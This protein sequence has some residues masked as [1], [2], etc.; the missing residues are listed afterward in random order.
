M[1][2]LPAVPSFDRRNPPSLKP[3]SSSSLRR[4]P[5][6][7]RLRTEHWRPPP[8]N[9]SG[10]GNPPTI[11]EVF[12]LLT[13]IQADNRN[14]REELQQLQ[15]K[16]K[17]ANLNGNNPEQKDDDHVNNDEQVKGK[18]R[19]NPL[20][21]EIMT[22]QMPTNFTLPTTLKAYD[23]IRDLDVHVTKFQNMIL[24]NGSISS[25]QELADLFTSHFVASAIY[26]HDLDYL[27]TIRQGQNESLREYITRFTKVA[28]E[29]P[30]LNAD[31]H[32]HALKSGLKFQEIIAVNKPKTLAEFRE[33][34]QGQMEIEEL[35]QA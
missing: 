34:A 30:N 13:E 17:D 16:P 26:Q 3:P 27:S 7:R 21:E 11:Q 35:R 20:F 18:K 31:V 2:H 33:K 25:F 8:E 19:N 4:G 29:I 28:M 15:N 14:I 1:V 9:T 23:G 6:F 24:L 10:N 12:N 5:P 32:L 22:F